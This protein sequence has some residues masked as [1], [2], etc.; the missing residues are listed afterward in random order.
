M[1]KLNIKHK[2]CFPIYKYRTSFSYLLSVQ[3]YCFLYFARSTPGSLGKM[4]HS[5]NQVTIT[6]IPIIAPIA[7]ILLVL[8]VPVSLAVSI[9]ETVTES[10]STSVFS[11][12]SVQF[13]LNA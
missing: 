2:K 3:S 9:V 10:L 6:F 12:P 5:P 11:M 13:S 1:A 7:C 8:D 4:S